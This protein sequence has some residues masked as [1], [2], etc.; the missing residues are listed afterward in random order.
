MRFL[1]ISLFLV[2]FSDAECVSIKATDGVTSSF[3][4]K[5]IRDMT[6]NGHLPTPS[7]MVHN[8]TNAPGYALLRSMSAL[9]EASRKSQFP[10]D[11]TCLRFHAE[12]DTNCAV[13]E[14]VENCTIVREFDVYADSNCDKGHVIERD[15][16]IL[17]S[18]L[19]YATGK[20]SFTE[21]SV[22]LNFSILHALETLGY[23]AKRE[24][25][26]YVPSTSLFWGWR[27]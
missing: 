16:S 15:V 24:R 8:P 13:L 2:S 12:G 10:Q 21:A 6:Y 5:S 18:I 7:A 25:L 3:I 4:R 11:S 26:E 22:R 1:I 14:S 9:M 17:T 20:I 19:W 27:L 23:Q